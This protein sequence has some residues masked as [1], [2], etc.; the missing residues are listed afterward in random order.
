MKITE[1]RSTVPRHAQVQHRDHKQVAHTALLGSGHLWD[2]WG[3]DA[4]VPYR[5]IR[6][7]QIGGFVPCSG[8]L[9]VGK[10]NLH[11][12][13]R[14]AAM[15]SATCPVHMTAG[16]KT[17]QLVIACFFNMLVLI[18]TPDLPR[19]SD[20]EGHGIGTASAPGIAPAGFLEAPAGLLTDIERTTQRSARCVA[21]SY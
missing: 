18:L 7:F 16:Y 15:C 9:R 13:G 21:D 2:D 10:E 14:C 1:A 8:R 4:E 20:W 6:T 17:H 5:S 12:A 11:V 19:K 3:P